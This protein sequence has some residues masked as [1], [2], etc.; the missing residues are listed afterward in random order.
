MVADLLVIDDLGSEPR[1]RNVTCEY[2][3]LV[4]EERSSRKLSTVITT[5]LSPD[6]IMR[7]YNE[8]IY[9]RMCDKRGSLF[10]PFTGDDLRLK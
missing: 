6:D 4:L 9:S 3:L 1:Y 10:L 8:R 2:L 7:Q 5:N